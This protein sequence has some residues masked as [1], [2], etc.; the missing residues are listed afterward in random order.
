MRIDFD[1]RWEDQMRLDTNRISGTSSTHAVSIPID[2]LLEAAA[3]NN[4]GR[5]LGLIDAAFT[6]E[7]S[8]PL[9]LRTALALGNYKPTRRPTREDFQ[10]AI[11]SLS[12]IDLEMANESGSRIRAKD[13][14][15]HLDALVR[16]R[17]RS[18]AKQI[19]RRSLGT[20]GVH[21]RELEWRG[22]RA[23]EIPALLVKR[24]FADA[25][26]GEVLWGR[27][28]PRELGRKSIE[29]RSYDTDVRGPLLV[30]ASSSPASG[31]R[32]EFPSPAIGTLMNDRALNYRVVGIVRLKESRPFRCGRDEG[33]AWCSAASTSYAW[34]VEPVGLLER[35]RWPDVCA[36]CL[37]RRKGSAE[38]SNHQRSKHVRVLTAR[39]RANDATESLLHD[40]GWRP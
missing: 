11:E 17:R 26:F 6:E 39:L 13:G 21:V 9:P 25:I 16:L 20:V 1:A 40:A 27:R 33:P 37:D 23:F 7:W 28:W 12:D 29:V 34:E 5:L 2:A 15:P 3:Y 35:L 32:H 18:I 24:P 22:E 8:E 14:V 19:A 30:A 4:I 31:W 38:Y 36:G 10:L